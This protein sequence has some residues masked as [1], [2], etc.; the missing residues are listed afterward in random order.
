MPRAKH[1]S[2]CVALTFRRSVSAAK[3]ISGFAA[4][5]HRPN[6]LIPD[7]SSTPEHQ[8][9]PPILQESPAPQKP[10]VPQ[11]SEWE[12]HVK[13]IAS[14]A[15]REIAQIL[16]GWLLE[17]SVL[18]SPATRCYEFVLR[19]ETP[20]SICDREILYARDKFWLVQQHILDRLCA[21]AHDIRQKA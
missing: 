8:P 15:E 6:V 19:A 17:I 14:L 18:E 2:A 9:P 20:E 5:I 16:P 3:A 11:E 7:V 21:F 13:T 4:L 10:L 1:I 12:Q